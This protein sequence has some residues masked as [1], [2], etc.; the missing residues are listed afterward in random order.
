MSEKKL[1]L[2][3]SEILRPLD[4]TWTANYVYP[5]SNRENLQIQI[6]KNYLK[7]HQFLQHF[8]SLSGIYIKFVIFSEKKKPHKSSISEV[9]DSEM[10]AYLIA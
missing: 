3:R 7:N 1:F 8:D 10:S 9:I 5:C 2:L 6:Q 4:N